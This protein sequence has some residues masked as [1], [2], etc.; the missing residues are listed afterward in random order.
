MLKEENHF[1]LDQKV[2]KV[3]EVLPLDEDGNVKKKKNKTL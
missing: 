3:K 2:G 1:A